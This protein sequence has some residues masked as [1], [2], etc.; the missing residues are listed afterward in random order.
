M[1]LIP[2]TGIDSCLDSVGVFQEICKESCYAAGVFKTSEELI[3]LTSD[4]VNAAIKKK[5]EDYSSRHIRCIESFIEQTARTSDE[6]PLYIPYYFI[7]VLFSMSFNE[8]HRGIKR[9]LLQEKIQQIHHRPDNV[10][11]SDIGNFAKNIVYSQIKKQISPPI[12]DYDYSTNSI[13][14]I[15]S[16]FY[17]FI[18]NCD[19]ETVLSDLNTPIGLE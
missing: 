18:R 2:P 7:R 1:P 3:I 17:F 19:K 15:D 10:R 5:L 16:T 14:I 12:F 6:I 9:K 4:H 13:K 11:A 8:V